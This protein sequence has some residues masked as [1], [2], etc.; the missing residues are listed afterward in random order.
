MTIIHFRTWNVFLR[1]F[2]QCQEA[3]QYGEAM[4]LMTATAFASHQWQ[5]QKLSAIFHINR[6]DYVVT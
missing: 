3:K 1:S 6:L 2:E 5:C 4:V